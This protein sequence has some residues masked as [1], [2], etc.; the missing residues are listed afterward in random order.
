MSALAIDC[1]S[2]PSGWLINRA[3]KK[4]RLLWLSSRLWVNTAI[5]I[6]PNHTGFRVSVWIIFEFVAMEN[7][8]LLRAQW[9]IRWRCPTSV[10]NP[11]PAHVSRVVMFLDDRW[12]PE[13]SRGSGSTAAPPWA[14]KSSSFPTSFLGF[15]APYPWGNVTFEVNIICFLV[16]LWW[17]NNGLQYAAK[18][19]SEAG[20]GSNL[21]FLAKNGD[22]GQ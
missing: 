8:L 19:E 9:R 10:S 7:P 1:G 21:A 11:S 2:P 4:K 14:S 20:D 12:Q 6:K 5:R 22:K 16:F 18:W 13:T 15:L 17:L 3:V